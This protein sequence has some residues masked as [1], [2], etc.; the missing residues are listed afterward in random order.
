[1]PTY[2]PSTSVASGESFTVTGELHLTNE[3][4]DWT[5]IQEENYLTIRNNKTGQRYKVLMEELPV[6]ED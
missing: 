1:M 2:T 6:N 4:G 5:I 3:K